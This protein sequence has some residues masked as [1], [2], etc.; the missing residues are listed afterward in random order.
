[1]KSDDFFNSYTFGSCGYTYI[2]SK[3]TDIIF[4]HDSCLIFKLN[5]ISLFTVAVDSMTNM[6][7]AVQST[8]SNVPPNN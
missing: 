8:Q 6:I 7:K 5:H 3:A 2:R 1:M 4:G